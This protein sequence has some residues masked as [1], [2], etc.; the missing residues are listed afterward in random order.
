MQFFIGYGS[1]AIPP[2]PMKNREHPFYQVYLTLV[3]CF[4]KGYL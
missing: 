4:C 1:P 2:A 3:L